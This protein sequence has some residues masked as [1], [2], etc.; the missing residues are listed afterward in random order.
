MSELFRSKERKVRDRTLAL[1][2][3][4]AIDSYVDEFTEVGDNWKQYSGDPF[5]VKMKYKL[6]RYLDGES[7]TL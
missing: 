4:D 5:Y 7:K 1:K 6:M 3:L 2:L